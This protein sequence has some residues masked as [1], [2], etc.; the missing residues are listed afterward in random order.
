MTL[1]EKE[2]AFL[3]GLNVEEDWTAKFTDVFDEKFKIGKQET[4]LYI[5]AG[6]GNHALGLSQK[7][8]EDSQMFAVCEN[9]ELR[10][11]A[12]EKANAVQANLEFSTSKPLL[13]SEFVLADGSFVKR[14][15][16]EAFVQ[17]AVKL[18]G[19]EIALFLSSAGSF[20]EVFSYL[21]EVFL[22]LDW[23][24]KSAD[25]ET[26]VAEFPSVSHLEETGKNLGIKKL[27][28]TTKAEFIDFENGKEFIEA[29]LIKYF[30]MPRWLDFLDENEKKQV[31]DKLAQKIDDERDE[32]SF[33]C[34]I[35]ATLITGKV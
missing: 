35:K 12:Q 30:F 29:P 15:E 23:L 26:L 32:L 24:D 33:R 19:K 2:L 3:R 16:L 17:S 25:I 9:D 11:I 1:S 6:S 14:C 4:F 31:I 8:D 34:S 21:W 27:K 28:A 5:N 20:G 22:D 10:K 13:E 18:S 7:L